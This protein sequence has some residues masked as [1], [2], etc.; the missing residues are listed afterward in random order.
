[1]TIATL[2]TGVSIALGERP[3]DACRSF[4]ANQDDRVEVSELIAAVNNALRGC[5]PPCDGPPAGGTICGTIT[6][7]SCS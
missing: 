1:V 4:D 3:L 6:S 2:V 5:P 7:R